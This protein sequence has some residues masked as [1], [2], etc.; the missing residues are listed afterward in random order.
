[1]FTISGKL[2]APAA[3]R[4]PKP[5]A[6]TAGQGFSSTSRNTI[7]VRCLVEHV[8][9]DAGFPEI[10]FAGPELRLGAFA[11]RRDDGHLARGHRHDHVIHLMGVM[12]GS[13][14]RRQPPFGDADFGC[15]DLNIGFGGEHIRFTLRTYGTNTMNTNTANTTICTQPEQDVGAAGAEG[16]HAEDEGQ[17]Q[18]QHHAPGALSP[19]TS[20]LSSA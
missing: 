6:Q 5:R 4:T 7:S 13:A 19:S 18:Q 14:A 17:Q 20:S 12:A 11:V 16:Q 1:M 3:A 10:G 8:V 15:I 2:N 9:L